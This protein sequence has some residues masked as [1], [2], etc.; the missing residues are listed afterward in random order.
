MVRRTALLLAASVVA[1]LTAQTTATST[2]G[3][4]GDMQ[5][6]SDAADQRRVETAFTETT[7]PRA[8]PDLVGKTGADAAAAVREA[9]PDCKV[10][11]VSV[12]AIITMDYNEQR[13]RIF[14]NDAGVVART[15]RVG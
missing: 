15:P 1:L 9:R 14:V 7:L 10:L 8:W 2:Q 4:A 6:R 11:I 12:D 5:Q 3:S 13:V